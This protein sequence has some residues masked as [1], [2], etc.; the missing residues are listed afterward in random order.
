MNRLQTFAALLLAICLP[1]V[2]GGAVCARSVD[3]PIIVK[4]TLPN[5]NSTS[6]FAL[7]VETALTKAGIDPKAATIPANAPG[8]ITV[9]HTDVFNLTDENQFKKYGAQVH[10]AHIN[11]FSA[12]LKNNTLNRGVPPIKLELAEM[13]GSKQPTGKEKY[14][15]VAALPA[16]AQGAIGTPAEVLWED[17]RFEEANDLL[18][19]FRIAVRLK[20]T[21]E[22]TP[23][24]P[25]P[26]GQLEFNLHFEVTFVLKV[27]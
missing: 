14:V 18:K 27:I 26:K 5:E 7:N 19:T 8:T 20:T 12:E 2:L 17:G 1:H 23:G 24:A 9:T 22:L 15:A 13:L 10:T 4:A 16:L 21:I 6:R 11:Y 3:L 25:M